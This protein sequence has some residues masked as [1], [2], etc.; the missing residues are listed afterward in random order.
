M[1][2]SGE[3]RTSGGRYNKNER[4]TGERRKRQVAIKESG[5]LGE[6]AAGIGQDTQK[7][8]DWISRVRGV[9]GSVQSSGHAPMTFWTLDGSRHAGT[10][11][12][13]R[14]AVI[15]VESRV[16]VLVGTEITVSLA[17]VENPSDAQELAEGTVVWHCPFSDEFENQRGFGV[18][19]RRHCREGR[20]PEAQSEQR[21]RHEN[22]TRHC[23]AGIW[24]QGKD[25]MCV[26]ATIVRGA[27]ISG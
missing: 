3:R 16:A 23:Q 6:G 10:M 20:A 14:S 12:H 11:P 26:G 24:S 25:R 1:L 18:I 7:Y 13:N 2:P 17:P 22:H 8:Q 15:F 5:P 21:R 9:G 19:L 4:R 27:V